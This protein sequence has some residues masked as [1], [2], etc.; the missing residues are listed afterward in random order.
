M[1]DLEKS[2]Q[3]YQERVAT[4]NEELRGLRDEIGRLRESNNE[5]QNR[6]NIKRLKDAIEEVDKS[7]SKTTR[8]L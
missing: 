2:V 5:S 7:G 6:E 1:E 4:L 3:K 8:K